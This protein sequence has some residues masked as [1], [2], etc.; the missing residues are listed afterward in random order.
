MLV[1]VQQCIGSLLPTIF[2]LRK[3]VFPSL[4]IEEQLLITVAELSTI[5]AQVFNINKLKSHLE[6]IYGACFDFNADREMLGND[7]I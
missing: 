1:N 3:R 6:R 4:S 7:R 5:E 2:C